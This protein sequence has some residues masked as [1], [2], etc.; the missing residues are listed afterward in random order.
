MKPLK[1]S[2]I[3]PEGNYVMDE[4]GNVFNDLDH[5]NE[6]YFDSITSEGVIK[7]NYENACEEYQ[8]LKDVVDISGYEILSIIKDNYVE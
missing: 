1:I 4:D 5:F 6:H 2:E 3:K 8:K 7:D